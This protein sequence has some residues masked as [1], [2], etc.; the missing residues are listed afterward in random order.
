MSEEMGKY[1]IIKMIWDH[2]QPHCSDNAH[3][4]PFKNLSFLSPFIHP[5]PHSQ[6]HTHTHIHTHTHAYTPTLSYSSTSLDQ[7]V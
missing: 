2:V 7:S 4:S 1:S 5:I 6:Q 3:V